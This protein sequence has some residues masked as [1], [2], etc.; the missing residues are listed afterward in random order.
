MNRRNLD[1]GAARGDQP[2]EA[3]PLGEP[4]DRAG[5]RSPAQMLA[6]RFEVL[7]ARVEVDRRGQSAFSRASSSSHARAEE[8]LR[9][10]EEDDARV[11]ELLAVDAR[12]DAD[13]G[14]IKRG[15]RRARM[16]SSTKLAKRSAR[17]CRKST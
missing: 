15:Q 5:V 2:V 10:A 7:R 11:D 16:A 8:S 12:D 14:V 1:D 3:V 17:R 13:D 4:A 6:E 9:G